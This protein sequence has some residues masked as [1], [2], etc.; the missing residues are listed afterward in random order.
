MGVGDMQVA[1]ALCADTSGASRP[2]RCRSISVPVPRFAAARPGRGILATFVAASGVSLLLWRSVF[3]LSVCASGLPCLM[4]GS[5]FGASCADTS[6]ASRPLRCRSVFVPVPRASDL[7]R[8]ASRG[9][10]FATVVA[11]SGV[12]LLL[13]RS[14]FALSVCAS[15]LTC[16]LLGSV[17]GASCADT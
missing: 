2:L 14:I 3:A 15:G 11:A 9:I 8:S 6:G 10:I 7:A 1:V 13:W 12:S 5:V 4:L 17:F 16:L